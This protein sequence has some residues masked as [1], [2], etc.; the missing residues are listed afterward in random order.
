M[1]PILESSG[2]LYYVESS[3]AGAET[4][5]YEWWHER[6]S[7]KVV[8]PSFIAFVDAFI[9]RLRSGEYVYRPDELAG[10]IDANDL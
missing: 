4:P 9:A 2:D 5:V 6:P 8:A 7:R 1:I 3:A 10:L